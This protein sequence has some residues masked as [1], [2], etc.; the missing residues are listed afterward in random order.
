MPTLKQMPMG[1]NMGRDRRRN[2][3]AQLPFQAGQQGSRAQQPQSLGSQLLRDALAILVFSLAPLSQASAADTELLWGDTHLHT[4]YSFDAFLN[5]NQSADPDTAYR[6]ARGMP[7]IHPYNRTRIQIETPL[8]FLVVSDHAEFYG[9]IRDIYYEG[10]Q[11]EDPGLIRRIAYWYNEREVRQAIDSGAGPE[12]FVNLLPEDIDPIAAASDWTATVSAST[13]PGA[14]VSARNAWQRMRDMA[15][16]HNQVDNFTAL[17]GWEWSSIPGGANLHRVVLTDASGEQAGQFMPFSSTQSPYPDDLWRWLEQT[18]SATGARFVAIPHNPNI[19]KGLMFADQ[20][21]RG[22]PID[23]TYAALRRKWEPVAEVTQIK[24]DSETHPALSPEDAFAD[25]EDYP[26]HIQ[27]QPT[28]RT[29][30]RPGDFARSGLKIGLQV[31][32]RTGINPY[33]FGMIGS[34]DS[35]TAMASAEEPNFW[36]KMAY[37]SI[38]ENKQSDSLGVGPTGWSMQAG[39]LAAVWA[40]QNSRAAILDAFARREVYATT[41]PRIAVRLFGGFDFAAEDLDRPDFS[42]HGYAQG[43]PMGG[44][45]RNVAKGIAPSFLVTAAHDPKGAYLDRIQMV[46]GWID[47]AGE[48]H[49]RVYD[50][51]ADAER[52][53]DSNGHFEAVGDSVNREDATFSNDIG[54]ATLRCYWQDPDFDSDQAAFYYVRVLQIPT[55]RH[56]L[57]DA[58]ALGLS[59]PSLG[60]AV[61]QERAYSSP[62]WYRP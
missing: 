5:G 48:T 37:D 27:Q 51:A 14:A 20:T 45:I 47:A 50:I 11:D 62:I 58:I 52:T 54:S 13:P 49:E 36:G 42:T 35:H 59:E 7:V 44:E 31:E 23:A 24:G 38:P 28:L 60:P 56:A 33:Q 39:G 18:A 40:T 17:L 8:D 29:D 2:S 4:S 21:L 22:E 15:E 41:G 19:S 43:V 12:Y 25:F 10:I 53:R 61:I 32:R 57:Y 55:P 26:W 34:T 16:R 46:K 1:T 9:G 30:H 6:Y 3:K